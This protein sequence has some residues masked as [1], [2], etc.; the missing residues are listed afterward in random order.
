MPAT[1]GAPA[2]QYLRMSTERQ[3]YSLQFQEAVISGYAAKNNFTI[4]KTYTDAGKSGLVL[5]NRTGLAALLQDV[6]SG[7]ELYR[8]I[9]VYDVSRWGRFQDADESAH[10]EFICRQAGVPIHYCAETFLNDGT[11]PSTIMKSL[12]RVMAAEYSRELSEK[13][14]L[15]MTRMVRDGRWPGSMPGYGLRRMLASN[16]RTP[17][18]EMRFGERKNLRSD[19]TLIVPGPPEEIA[20][21]KEIF[22]LYA[23]ER[24]SFPYIARKLNDLGIPRVCNGSSVRWTY[25]AVRQIILNEKYSGS[26]IWGRY[27]QKLRSRCVPVLRENW[28]VARDV[29]RPIVNRDIFEAAR[30][31]WSHKTWQL[32]DEEF[33]DRLRALLKEKG[34]L[35]ARLI[36]ESSLTPSCTAYLGRFGSMERVYD[37]I[38]YRRTDTY[39]LRKLSSIR[40]TAIYRSL[41]CR[42][43]RLF[44]DLRATHERSS[45][46]PKGIRFST[47]LTAA[48]AVC[49]ADKTLKG[50]RR[51]RFESQYAQNSGLPTLLC[52][53]AAANKTIAHFVLVPNASHIHCIS[54]LK[55]HDKRLEDGIRLRHLRDFRR[56]AHKIGRIK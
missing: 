14:T 29:F 21:V 25:Q 12:K 4:V 48:V 2:A 37:L 13:I 55:E 24:R 1:I 19:R 41:Y 33:L 44:P 45:S 49:P 46:R 20:I 53:C 17:K 8:A 23:K 11:M 15:A 34:R 28:I 42:L 9:L 50:E 54:M 39:M 32:S 38:D 43:L 27:T 6:I 26:L 36:N 47:G 10:Y 52:F 56:V 5:K 16:D 3:Q 7:N 35:N 31:I 51:W 22:R 30:A 18:C 40:I